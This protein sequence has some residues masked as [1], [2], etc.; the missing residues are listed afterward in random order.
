[1]SSDS[2][3]ASSSLHYGRSI[4]WRRRM[5]LINRIRRLP[6]EAITVKIAEALED[7]EQSYEVALDIVYHELLL[8]GRAREAEEVDGRLVVPIDNPPVPP[9][10][11]VRERL[12]D[13]EVERE[14][15]LARLEAMEDRIA[16]LEA[17]LPK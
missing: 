15:L 11:T 14:G 7:E 9:G 4:E 5:D 10:P 13:A 6:S 2:S 16:D 3:A 8:S 12:R 17:Q 1:M